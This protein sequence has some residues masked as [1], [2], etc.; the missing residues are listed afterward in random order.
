[1]GESFWDRRGLSLGILMGGVLEGWMVGE[2]AVCVLGGFFGEYLVCK[3]VVK[4]CFF[5]GGVW[6][7]CR[8]VGLG[9]WWMGFV[10]VLEY[11]WCDLGE[12]F[13]GR[14]MVGGMVYV[15]VRFGGRD[16]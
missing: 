7:R 1:M 9:V 8:V 16:G 15:W 6:W 3:E 4:R 5:G 12:V 10:N 14:V 11:G 2:R 13:W